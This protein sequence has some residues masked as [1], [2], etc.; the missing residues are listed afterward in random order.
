[1][2]KS[3]ARGKQLYI[4]FIV[5]LMP[6]LYLLVRLFLLLQIASYFLVLWKEYWLKTS[7]PGFSPSPASISHTT[8][9]MSLTS[10]WFYS[11]NWGIKYNYLQIPSSSKI[12]IAYQFLLPKPGMVEERDYRNELLPAAKMTE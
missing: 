12:Q 2:K 4:S 5:L 6:W 8:S 11:S 9:H 1:M 7:E 10:L 3:F